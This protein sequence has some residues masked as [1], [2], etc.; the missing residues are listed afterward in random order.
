MIK[1][2]FSIAALLQFMTFAGLII[3]AISRFQSI[4]LQLRP[5]LAGALMLTV[6]CI[7]GG[8]CASQRAPRYAV[9]GISLI[10][11]L[12]LVNGWSAPFSEINIRWLYLCASSG[13]LLGAFYQLGT[14]HSVEDA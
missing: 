8:I 12:V 7:V 11:Y 5:M 6:G 9:I 1:P 10:A 2:R 4:L 14:D 3:A 13:M